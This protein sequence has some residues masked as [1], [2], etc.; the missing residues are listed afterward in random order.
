MR[1][2][3]GTLWRVSLDYASFF[4]E[5]AQVVFPDKPSL[6]GFRGKQLEHT[7]KRTRR[8]ASPFM[9]GLANSP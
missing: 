5:K 3:L 4:R 7:P 2:N 6:D 1:S 8:A 9:V